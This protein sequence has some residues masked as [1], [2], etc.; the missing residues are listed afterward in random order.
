MTERMIIRLDKQLTRANL[1]VY[2]LETVTLGRT[3]SM[4]PDDFG[5]RVAFHRTV[6]NLRLS[7]DPILIIGLDPKTRRN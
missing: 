4:L 2:H 1:I 6:E 3:F 5:W 7:V